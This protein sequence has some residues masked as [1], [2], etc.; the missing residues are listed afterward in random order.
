MRSC[1]VCSTHDLI[2]TYGN[3]FDNNGL[4]AREIF[5][6]FKLPVSFFKHFEARTHSE[7]FLQIVELKEVPSLICRK[8]E[9]YVLQAAEL[10]R[11][12]LKSNENF[13]RML[14]NERYLWYENLRKL[15]STSLLE[16]TEEQ[17]PQ[18]A[19]APEKTSDLNNSKIVDQVQSKLIATSSI[20]PLLEPTEEQLPQNAN[21]PE[22]TSDFCNSESVDQVQS[23]L[24]ATSPETIDNNEP[25]TDAQAIASKMTPSTDFCDFDT[26]DLDDFIKEADDLLMQSF[27]EILPNEEAAEKVPLSEIA[28]TVERMKT[29]ANF[30]SVSPSAFTERLRESSEEILRDLDNV[31]LRNITDEQIF[32]MTQDIARILTPELEDRTEEH[33]KRKKSK[34]REKKSKHSS[35]PYQNTIKID[36]KTSRIINLRTVPVTKCANL[37]HE[38]AKSVD[39]RKEVSL[40][41]RSRIFCSICNDKFKNNDALL[42]HLQVKHMPPNGQKRRSVPTVK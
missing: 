26:A 14:N 12:Y 30:G 39:Q 21:S 13:R 36:L 7:Y 35:P 19:N 2:N 16:S 1:R 17:L 10:K 8:C 31:N 15:K 23:K 38:V 41:R 25:S 29:E 22:E 5:D 37:I 9:K 27:K 28:Q 40:T 33:T 34:K 20:A 42:E 3:C 18:K 24:I 4:I 11:M 6:L 32:Q